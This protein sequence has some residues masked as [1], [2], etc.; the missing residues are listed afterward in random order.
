MELKGWGRK[1]TQFLDDQGRRWWELK[2]E[3]EDR[4]RWKRSLPMQHKEEGTYCIFHKSMELLISSILYNNSTLI[5]HRTLALFL[6]YSV[7]NSKVLNRYFQ[8][9]RFEENDQQMTLHLKHPIFTTLTLIS[10]QLIRFSFSILFPS[11]AP[12]FVHMNKQYQNHS[13]RSQAPRLYLFSDGQNMYNRVVLVY[14]VTVGYTYP[15]AWADGQFSGTRYYI[16]LR[17][18]RGC[19]APM[20]DLAAYKIY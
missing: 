5:L 1:I 8:G 15:L 2:E 18:P 12:L 19:L 10:A 7:Q 6:L 14:T 4:K 16:Y 3:A 20:V 11:K 17:C 9:T 13:P